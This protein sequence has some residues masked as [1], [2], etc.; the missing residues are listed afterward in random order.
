[1]QKYKV[2]INNQ[3]EIITEN[4]ESF[5]KEYKIII[6]AG[7][8]VY[9]TKDQILMIFRNGKWDLPKG[10]L[11]KWETSEEGAIREVTEECGVSELEI[12]RPLQDTYHTYKLDGEKILKK[13]FWFEMRSFHVDS[14]E[15][16]NKEGITL[17]LWVEKKDIKDKLHNSYGNIVELLNTI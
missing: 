6:A 9:N 11:D 14:L 16:E 17:A 1:M 12:I 8:L 10:K 7:G 15:P 5:C 4:W 2:Y 13:I 3:L